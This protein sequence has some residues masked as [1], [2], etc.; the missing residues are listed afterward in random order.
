[1]EIYLRHRERK[2]FICITKAEKGTIELDVYQSSHNENY[3]I[4]KSSYD[5]SIDERHSWYI[6]QIDHV[7]STGKLGR[8][9]KWVK[10]SEREFWSGYA[11]VNN[12]LLTFNLLINR[13]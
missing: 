2:Q 13:K 12:D 9:K 6:A 5:D 8:V 4:S 11:E 1:M 10:S 7:N 3:D